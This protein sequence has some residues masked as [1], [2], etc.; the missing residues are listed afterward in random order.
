MAFLRDRAATGD[1]T[2]KNP[3][4]SQYAPLR[5]LFTDLN[6]NTV[7]EYNWISPNQYNDMHTTLSGGFAGLSG[8]RRRSSRA[9]RS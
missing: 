2:P 6:T 3:M 1:P 7:A 5:Q 9:I 4:R 8:D